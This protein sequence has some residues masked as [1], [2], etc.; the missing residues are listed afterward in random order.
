[1]HQTFDEQLRHTLD[2]LA[3]RLRRDIADHATSTVEQLSHL[4]TSELEA[5]ERAA[6]ARAEAVERE[7]TRRLTEEFTARESQ[8]RESAHAEGF[9][10]GMVQARAEAH[11]IAA[12]DA[13]TREAARMLVEQGSCVRLL[14]AIR[15]LDAATSLSQ[16]LDALGRAARGDA[17]RAV[18]LL[19]RGQT[20]K[21]WGHHGFGG[22]VS[23]EVP[24]EQAGIAADAIRSGGPERADADSENRPAFAGSAE[25]GALVAVPLQMNGHVVAVLVGESTSA[26]DGGEWLATVYEV[27]ARHAARVLESLTALRLAQLGTPAAATAAPAP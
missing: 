26:V 27:L 13:Q 8:V 4:F 21:S 14:D 24:L 23:I 10:A 22:E 2:T 6:H 7:V 3:E 20:L 9:T 11:E 1:M 19:L 5:A 18:V 25:G 15:A 17:E 16:T 12:A